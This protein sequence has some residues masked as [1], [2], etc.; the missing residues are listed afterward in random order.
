[1]DAT[2][3]PGSPAA[4]SAADSAVADLSLVQLALAG[5][6]QQIRE[7]VLRLSCVP[8]FVRALNRRV[9]RPLDDGDLEDLAQDVVGEVWR[10]LGDYA[11][12]A[13]LETWIFRF[14]DLAFRNARRRVRKRAV[15]VDVDEPGNETRIWL[16]VDEAPG[17]SLERLDTLHTL[18]DAL[19]PQT[20]E[21]LEMRF[22]EE[23]SL[24]QIEARSGLP[25]NA[26]RGRI[27]RALTR[28]R[29]QSGGMG[30]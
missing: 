8:R 10:R 16:P 25:Q 24:A 30:E 2:P 26:V 13:R 15:A 17:A 12:L 20:R 4:E 1:V 7:L 3:L 14:A 23:L 11:G 6:P 9:G 28:L 18:L 19:E 21:L 5:E 27:F 29:T 22:L